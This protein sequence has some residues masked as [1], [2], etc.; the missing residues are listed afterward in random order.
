M[1]V[2]RS[3]TRAATAT[4]TRMYDDLLRSM[5]ASLRGGAP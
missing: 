2:G 3:D 4:A 1:S 5:S